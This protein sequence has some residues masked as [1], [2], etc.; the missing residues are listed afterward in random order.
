MITRNCE[1]IGDQI[2]VTYHLFRRI[3]IYRSSTS[4]IAWRIL[5]DGR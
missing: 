1:Y 5:N 2:I 3:L 4:Y